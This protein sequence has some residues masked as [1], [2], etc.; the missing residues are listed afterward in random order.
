[1]EHANSRGVIEKIRKTGRFFG[2]QTDGY[3]RQL[4]ARPRAMQGNIVKTGTGK[5]FAGA[6]KTGGY[7]LE[8]HSEAQ[9]T[10][11]TIAIGEVF[12]TGIDRSLA[13]DRVFVSAPV[14]AAT[15][16]D[17]TPKTFVLAGKT[18]S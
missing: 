13:I 1:M 11:V 3:F 12:E 10:F 9:C 14:I 7:I 15:Q 18:R 16:T 17:T 4:K 5:L 6:C 8:P 2:H